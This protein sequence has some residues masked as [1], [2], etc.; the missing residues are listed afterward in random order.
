MKLCDEVQV[1]FE[2]LDINVIAK[3]VKTKFDVLKERYNS[4][5][6]GSIRASLAQTVTDRNKSIDKMFIDQMTRVDT[7]I[8]NKTSWLTAANGYVVARLNQDGSWKELLF[9]DTNDPTTAR[10][11][12]RINNLGIGIWSYAVS[13]G[14]VLDG[15]YDTSWTISG[16]IGDAAGKNFWNL[17]TGEFALSASTTVGGM[18]V[19]EIAE[20]AVSDMDGYD[21]MRKITDDFAHEG[22][23]LQN[24]HLYINGTA[25]AVGIISDKLNKNYWNLDTG[26]FSLQA[27]VT[28]G[29]KT[30]PTI[31]GESVSAYDATLNQMA[32]Y[33]KLTNGQSNQGIWLDSSTGKLYIN[34]EMMGAGTILIGGS[35]YLVKPALLI[36]DR[37]NRE[38]GSWTTDGIVAH[39]GSFGLLTIEVD[40]S[41]IK[42]VGS[43]YMRKFVIPYSTKQRSRT[44]QFTIG[45]KYFVDNFTLHFSKPTIIRGPVESGNYIGTVG[46]GGLKYNSSTGQWEQTYFFGGIGFTDQ[47]TIGDILVDWKTRGFSETD[48]ISI[49]FAN[50][51]TNPCK[52]SIEV[53]VLNTTTL[54]LSAARN[55]GEFSGGFR[56]TF[57]GTVN[58]W[59]WDDDSSQMQVQT[60]FYN[61]YY[62]TTGFGLGFKE[63]SGDTQS[64]LRW[65]PEDGR[66]LL[67]SNRSTSDERGIIVSN[68][69]PDNND[70][71][72]F[73]GSGCYY[74]IHKPTSFLAKKNGS[75][76]YGSL[77]Y[78]RLI[79][80]D[81]SSYSSKVIKDK[82]EVGSSYIYSR[83]TNGGLQ[84]IDS[85]D[86]ALLNVESIILNADGTTSTMVA[87][88]SENALNLNHGSGRQIYMTANSDEATLRVCSSFASKWMYLVSRPET[89]DIVRYDGTYQSVSW[90]T[91]DRRAKEDIEDLDIDLSLNIIDATETKRF[92]YKG[93]D[94]IHYGAIAQDMR[95][96]LDSLGETEAMLEHSMGITGPDAVMDDQ[97]TIDYHEY[98]ALLINYVKFLRAENSQRKQEIELLRS[99][100]NDLKN[101]LC[102]DNAK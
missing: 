5:E 40:S 60:N 7:A 53:T 30:I 52:F 58:E 77:E 67:R 8:T 45:A 65:L 20:G 31:A 59:S 32:I 72:D 55:I 101:L 87:N 36:K 94:G 28:V 51:P 27:G 26:A 83:L 18:T 43:R 15:P 73:S 4:V 100:I 35:S 81:N 19:D 17:L 34:G 3:V 85:S 1:Y 6:I 11:G 2:Q 96:V 54:L 10:N 39:K 16:R 24:N 64:V 99:E 49:G 69:N 75:N 66:L 29:G 89:Q 48:K 71:N 86:G 57:E 46:V 50:W 61:N 9:M 14:N 62:S 37:S 56:G 38:I 44:Y 23:W 41:S 91:S 93:M 98:T 42:A 12:V 80:G 90:N 13:G 102:P 79:I 78:D 74:T 92:K 97:R 88:N 47:N 76:N 95:E 63:Y 22:M 82:I 33:N 25:L 68:Y 84:I 70:S 21:V